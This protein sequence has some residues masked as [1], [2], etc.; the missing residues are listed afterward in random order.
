MQMA[1]NNVLNDEPPPPLDELA[2]RL[3]YSSSGVLRTYFS[4]L[5]DRILVRRQLHRKLQLLELKRK[6]QAALLE[7]PAP[8]VASLCRRLNMCPDVLRRTCP[9]ECALIRSRYVHTG[10]EVGER[11][12]EQL[13]QEVDRL[14]EKLHSEGK[15]PSTGRV[16]TRLSKTTL[17][18][19]P[20][21]R[22]AV[23]D[24]RRELRL[25]HPH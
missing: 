21:V 22:A 7:W 8:C 24:T 4:T 14:V 12:Q 10:R 2:R 5:C 17:N 25:S 6:L 19:W 18:C 13:R 15:Y 3:D 9:Y 11:R 1:L 20:T 23:E 16:S